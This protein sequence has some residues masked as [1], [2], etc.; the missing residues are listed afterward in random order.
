[1]LEPFADG[2]CELDGFSMLG[3]GAAGSCGF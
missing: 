1:V 3:V 2:G